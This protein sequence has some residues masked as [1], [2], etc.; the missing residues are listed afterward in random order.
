MAGCK[1]HTTCLPEMACDKPKKQRFKRYPIGFFHVDIADLR[2]AEGKLYLFIA[3]DRTSEFAVAQLVEE[4]GRKTAWE[5]LER[6]LETVS[7]RIHTILTDHRIQFADQ[8]RNRNTIY[9]RPTGAGPLPA[10]L[11]P[12]HRRRCG[13]GPMRRPW[14]GPLATGRS[15][16]RSP[17][18]TGR[19]SW[20]WHH[21]DWPPRH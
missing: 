3:I 10:D 7:Y 1:G 14:P 2:T 17:L 9:S 13:S 6:L 8:Q 21:R 12:M 19:H 16:T 5:F 4:A 11:L 15:R 18:R 20:W